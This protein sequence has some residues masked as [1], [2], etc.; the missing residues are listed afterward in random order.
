MILIFILLI[1][2]P[3]MAMLLRLAVSRKREYLADATAVQLTRYPDGLCNAL[4][5]LE[6]DQELLEAAN[7]ATAHMYIVNPLK[8]R[9]I[10]AMAIFSTHP[11]IGERIRKLKALS[12]NP[13]FLHGKPEMPEMPEMPEIP[14][15]HD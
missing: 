11:P 7:S 1:L 12:M 13:E 4:I 2:A 14:D 5:K 9:L 15:Q 10:D 6:R 3:I 8:Q